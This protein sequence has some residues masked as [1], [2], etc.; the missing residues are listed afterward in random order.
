M[1]A[2][3]SSRKRA[4]SQPSAISASLPDSAKR[5]ESRFQQVPSLPRKA[6]RPRDPSAFHAKRRSMSQSATPATQCACQTQAPKV[7]VNVTQCHA[8]QVPHLPHKA[9]AGVT[10]CHTCPAQRKP[11]AQSATHATQ[12]AKAPVPSTQT[13]SQCHQV[14]HLPRK[15][16]VDGAKC[17]ACHPKHIHFAPLPSI[18]NFGR[19]RSS[20]RMNRK[21]H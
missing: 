20:S 21:R 16:K 5:N 7:R 8:C 3:N 4:Q 19:L 12:S 15:A 17:R 6:G 2:Y 18:G 9:K 10:T 11:M 14:P 13:E 1:F